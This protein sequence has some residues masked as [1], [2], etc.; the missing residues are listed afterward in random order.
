MTLHMTPIKR[1]TGPLAGRHNGLRQPL[2][3]CTSKTFS[4]SAHFNAQQGAF[5]YVP[6]DWDRREGGGFML[7]DAL[8][9]GAPFL[10]CSGASLP[11]SGESFISA[12]RTC[13]LWWTDRIQVE[14]MNHIISLYLSHSRWS[15]TWAPWSPPP[16]KNK[17]NKNQVNHPMH[18]TWAGTVL[19]SSFAVFSCVWL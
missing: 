19:L 11:S 17:K 15:Q 1:W 8:I 14:K 10:W 7:S 12:A 5:V 13:S 16:Q 6:E 9:S 18:G 2:S 4:S 3:G